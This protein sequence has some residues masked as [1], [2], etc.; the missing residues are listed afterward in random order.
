[1]NN[2]EM[3]ATLPETTAIEPCRMENPLAPWELTIDFNLD[4]LPKTL[5]DEIDNLNK[6]TAYY[7]SQL[8]GNAE[9]KRK[10]VE[11]VVAWMTESTTYG[12]EHFKNDPKWERVWP[13]IVMNDD[14]LVG[15]NPLTTAQERDEFEQRV[16]ITSL[17]KDTITKEKKR[18]L[19]ERA[20]SLLCSRN[21]KDEKFFSEETLQ[22]CLEAEGLTTK[23]AVNKV[24][25]KSPSAYL[26]ASNYR[27]ALWARWQERD[28]KKLQAHRFESGNWGQEAE[29]VKTTFTLMVMTKATSQVPGRDWNPSG[30]VMGQLQATIY[31]WL[32]AAAEH[33]ETS[34]YLL[35]PREEDDWIGIRDF[36]LTLKAEKHEE[37]HYD[38]QDG[39]EKA[40]RWMKEQGLP[41]FY[42]ASNDWWAEMPAVP[43]K[44]IE[45]VLTEGNEMTKGD[46]RGSTHYELIREKYGERL[47]EVLTHA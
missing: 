18:K 40:Q 6:N 3:L 5:R 33:G 25:D 17:L 47:A 32:K 1:M 37:W 42:G 15:D 21:P 22:E 29:S 31:Q 41:K 19:E 2:D 34:E 35:D 13:A 26:K 20:A 12:P 27:E 23:E 44:D 10:W 28:E 7:L 38:C 16:L 11:K 36:L 43:M 4:N 24:L 14:P 45:R 9:A 39:G 46:L 8:Y 30:M